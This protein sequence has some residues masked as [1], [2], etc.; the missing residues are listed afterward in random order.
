MSNVVGVILLGQSNSGKSTLGKK[1]AE[2]MKMEYISSG[3]IARSM[4]ADVQRKLNAGEMAPEDEMRKQIMCRINNRRRYGG[5]ILD[6]FPRFND[7]YVWLNEHAVG[8]EFVYVI[9]DVPYIDILG[10]AV[11]RRRC[12]DDSISRKMEWYENNTV[13][14]IKNI[15]SDGRSVYNIDNGDS[16]DPYRNINR[17]CDIVR[18]KMNEG[19]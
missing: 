6:G 4:S 1:L 13:P 11:R 5:F 17:L 12:D 3:D 7:Q 10:R 9:V 16:D 2:V 8:I 15:I 18:S 14:M 19:C